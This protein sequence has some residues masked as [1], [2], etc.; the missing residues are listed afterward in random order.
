CFIESGSYAF[1]KPPCIRHSRARLKSVCVQYRN[2]LAYL[3]SMPRIQVNHTVE[4]YVRSIY[5][6]ES[7]EGKASNAALAR[8]FN[9]SA[10]AV[11]EMLRRLGDLGLL[12]YRKYRVSTLTPRG[13]EIAVRL[14]RR[15]R[16]WEVFLI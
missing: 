4:D 14:T 5:R 11:T 16:L 8:E 7:R 12:E 13:L 1:E 15:H 6:L 9:I 2:W 10:A 3:L